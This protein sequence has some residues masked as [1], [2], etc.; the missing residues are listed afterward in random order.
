MRCE[1]RGHTDAVRCV[2]ATSASASAS[3]SSQGFSR[4]AGVGVVSGSLDSTVR[5][6]RVGGSAGGGL[7]GPAGGEDGAAATMAGHTGIVTCVAMGP[8]CAA[9]PGGAVVSG[10][11]DMTSIVWDAA[12]GEPVH[13]LIGHTQHVGGAAVF[14]DG[15][16]VTGAQDKSVRVWRGGREVACVEDAHA[17]SVLAV[18]AL[19]GGAWEE[20]ALDGDDGGGGVGGTSP[21]RRSPAGGAAL[22]SLEFLTGG[23]DKV[24]KR[25]RVAFSGAPTTCTC[26]CTHT[27]KGHAD[28]VRCL[29]LAPDGLGFLSGSHDSTVR[30]WALSGETLGEFRSHSSLVFC[31]A[32]THSGGERALVASGGEDHACV[33]TDPGTGAQ[34]Q[35]LPHPGVVWGASFCDA[36]GD[37]VTACSDGALRVWTR[38]PSRAAGNAEHEASYRAALAEFEEQQKKSNRGFDLGD[39]PGLEAL[40]RP[41]RKD[42][43]VKIVREGDTPM[44]YTWDAG[45]TTWSC[46][47]EVTDGPGG[48]AAAGG[49]RGNGGVIDGTPYDHVFTVEL[50]GGRSAKLGFNVGDNPYTVADEWLEAQ[51]LPVDAFKAEL[52]DL[53]LRNV[54]SDEVAVGVAVSD[55]FTGAGAYVPPPPSR[56]VRGAEHRDPRQRT[57]GAELSSAE[58]ERILMGQFRSAGGGIEAERAGMAAGGG[59]AAPVAAAAAGVAGGV[60]AP[61]VGDDGLSPTMA[62]F[63][64]AN[65][66]A[67]LGKLREFS[68]ALKASAGPSAAGAMEYKEVEELVRLVG[69]LRDPRR[70][71]VTTVGAKGVDLVLKLMFWPA[72]KLFPVLDLFKAVVL[73]PDGASRLVQRRSGGAV[74]L[75]AQAAGAAQRAPAGPLLQTALKA[76][77]NAAASSDLRGAPDARAWMAGEGARAVVALAG[78]ALASP[79]KPTRVALAG[80]LLNYALLL[81]HADHGASDVLAALRGH[82]AA[83]RPLAD[84]DGAADAA[85]WLDAAERALMQ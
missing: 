29:A 6:W 3:A 62:R 23:A 56:E 76:L 73:H 2:A 36:E 21:G 17:S 19:E 26:I 80:C 69:E 77:A 32:A 18:L 60:S 31:V 22:R 42:G 83:L 66:D 67:C 63:E 37:L 15:T 27:Y 85:A 57:N 48:G 74:A 51:G 10:S 61:T 4:G 34:V 82:V 12:T 11:S 53:I 14:P 46:V 41:G 65:W 70:W 71:H 68:D 25:W 84:A 33:L 75:L 64:G 35:A 81:S 59:A 5:T 30:L 55:P 8:P 40:A 52:V 20:D 72:D 50:D 45:S 54:P 58:I 9:Y 13:T 78:P 79:S 24:V 39:L 43:Q 49:G 7:A 44:A 47:G 1:L 38:E 16:V 28:T